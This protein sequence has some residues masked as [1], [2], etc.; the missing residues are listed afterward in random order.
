[1]EYNKTTEGPKPG[2]LKYHF[3]IIQGG[4]LENYEGLVPLSPPVIRPLE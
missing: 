2:P 3:L 4:L 1:M